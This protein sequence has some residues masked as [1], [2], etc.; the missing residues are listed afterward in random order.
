MKMSDTRKG[1]AEYNQRQIQKLHEQQERLNRMPI[2]LVEQAF[3]QG[4][5]Q[6]WWGYSYEFKLPLD[7]QLANE[8][9]FFCDLQGF[10]Y[11]KSRQHLWDEG[12]GSAGLFFDVYLD[13]KE[14]FSVSMRSEIEG[15][16][17]KLQQIGTKEVPVYEVTCPDGAEENTWE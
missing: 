6:D 5:W 9:R 7:F 14:N 16:T 17:C 13:N 3:P 12:G 1:L 2:E 8:F 10:T 15:S 11:S 4:E